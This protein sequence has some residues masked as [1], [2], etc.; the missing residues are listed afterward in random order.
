MMAKPKFNIAKSDSE[1]LGM[2]SQWWQRYGKFAAAGLVLVAGGLGGWQGW[3][4]YR[5]SHTVEAAEAYTAFI[6][7]L[8][9]DTAADGV[10][11]EL[12]S[13]SYADTVY[14]SFAYLQRARHLV[15]HGNLTQAAEDLRWVVENS[16]QSALSQLARV[17]LARVLISM[18]ETQEALILLDDILFLDSFTPLVDEARGD[19]LFKERD[20]ASAATAYR[21]AWS[22]SRSKLDFLLFK[23]ESLG[24]NVA[25]AVP[26]AQ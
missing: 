14:L 26:P 21:G 15:N 8:E 11:P 4:Y 18:N 12:P 22:A 17:R 25:P 2:L 5:D 13:D 23:L 19:A 20:A 24:Q 16:V 6:Q 3:D 9:T 1:A 7:E 10:L